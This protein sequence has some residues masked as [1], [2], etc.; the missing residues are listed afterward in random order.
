MYPNVENSWESYGLPELLITDRGK[1][2]MSKHLDDAC[3]QL[4]IKLEHTPGHLGIKVRLNVI[5]KH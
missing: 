5:S 1:D 4:G 3:S 2:F